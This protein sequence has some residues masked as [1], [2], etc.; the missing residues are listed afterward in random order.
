MRYHR[1]TKVLMDAHL[2][3]TFGHSLDDYD[4]LHQIARF[5]GPIP[6]GELAARLVVANSSCHRIVGRL[7]DAG[8]VERHQ[9][10]VDRRQVFVQLTAEGRRLRRRMAAVHTRDIED[11][12]GAALSAEELARLHTTLERLMATR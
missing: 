4:V 1:Q 6:M 3:T 9:G 7:S 10:A 11:V 2:R 8:F 12:F 5:G